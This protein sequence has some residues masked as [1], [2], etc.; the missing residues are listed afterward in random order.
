[1]MTLAALGL[2][3]SLFWLFFIGLAVGLIGGFIG[4]G[5]GF[6]R[7]P[8]MIYFIGVPSILAVGTD[9]F[10]IIISGAYGLIRHTMSGMSS[11][12]YR[13]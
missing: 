7:M 2:H 4:V 9:L 1:M 13:W 11:S 3:I 12:K 5:G 6:V 8:S 10:E